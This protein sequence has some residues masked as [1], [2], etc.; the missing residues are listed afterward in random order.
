M[1]LDAS[2]RDVALLDLYQLLRARGAPPPGAFTTLDEAGQ[3]EYFR[4]SRARSR[5]KHRA[6]VDAGRIPATDGNIRAAL[7]DAALMLLAI[8][9]PGADQVRQVLATVFR[10][11]AGVPVS[12]EMRARSGRLK[13]KLMERRP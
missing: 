9:G 8:D 3:R 10:D 4:V 12:V 11:K 13:P 7:S 2:K 6:A 5:A 1:S